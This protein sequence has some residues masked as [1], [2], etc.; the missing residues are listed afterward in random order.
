MELPPRRV[1]L[2]LGKGLELG[3]LGGLE[4]VVWL[5]SSVDGR[6]YSPEGGRRRAAE[7]LC[8]RETI[9]VGTD[10]K[11][12]LCFAKPREFSS[13]KLRQSLLEIFELRRTWR[14]FW[15]RKPDHQR[16]GRA[17]QPGRAAGSTRLKLLT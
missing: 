4:R 13:R 10:H 11:G 7:G 14:V 8:Y 17:A 3:L 9:R 2:P 6:G 16:S 1:E 15:A 12:S 5:P